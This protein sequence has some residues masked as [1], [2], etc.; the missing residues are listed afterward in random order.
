MKKIEIKV[1]GMMCEGCE[2]R[3][4]NAVERIEGIE[5][6]EADHNKGVVTITA[7]DDMNIETVK[8]K[9]KDIGFQVI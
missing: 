6:V 9:I 4:R 5:K 1:D 8:E 3:I 7:K 2:N